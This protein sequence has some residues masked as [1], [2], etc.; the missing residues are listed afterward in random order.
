M[1]ELDTRRYLF[2]TINSLGDVASTMRVGQLLAALGEICED[3]HGRGLWDAEDAELLEAGWK[4]KQD[5]EAGAEK[6]ARNEVPQIGGK[7]LHESVA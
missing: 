5:L 4:F 2:E 6:V 3:L 7:V 1:T